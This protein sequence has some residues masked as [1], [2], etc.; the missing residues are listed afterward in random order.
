LKIS[1]YLLFLISFNVKYDSVYQSLQVNH[2]EEINL[3]KQPK[4]TKE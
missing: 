2:L 3:I 4:K 1:H